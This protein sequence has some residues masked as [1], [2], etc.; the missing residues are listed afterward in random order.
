MNRIKLVKSQKVS[1]GRKRGKI[2]RAEQT[3]EDKLIEG[4]IRFLGT[5]KTE[6]ET[7]AETVRIAREHG[8]EAYDDAKDYLPGRR[9]YKTIRNR[10]AVFAVMGE[11]PLAAGISILLA[12][13]DS[14]RLDVKPNPVYAEEPCIYFDTHYYGSIKKYQWVTI[15]LAL[16]GRVVKKDGTEIPIRIGENA[17]D[18]VLN[19]S[20]LPPHI[21]AR[22]LQ[23][24]AI[25]FIDGERLNVI[26]GTGGD[27]G[28]ADAFYKLLQEK[29][30]IEKEDFISADI[31]IVPAV[32]PSYVGLDRSMI[33]GY[34]QDD[35]VCVFTALCSLLAQTRPKYTSL[36]ILTDR[37]EVGSSGATGI[38]SP[39][40]RDFIEDLAD[41]EHTKIRKVMEKSLCFSADVI[42]TAD[43]NFPEELEKHNMCRLGGG[44][45]ISRYRGNNGKVD[46]Q[47]ATAE[48]LALTRR[49]F[50][51]KHVAFQTG[52]AGKVDAGGGRTAGKFLSN[53]NVDTV[54]VGVPILSMHSPYEITAVSDVQT[55]Y[56]AYRAFLE[57]TESI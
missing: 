29:Y 52:E 10:S 46:T 40:F 30:N 51:E 41:R 27:N 44:A 13:A 37:E 14:P 43:P 17:G 22:Q 28:K 33:G 11:Q 4:Y 36:L 23:Q 32:K 5:A 24:K 47:D 25:D 16:H 31:A 7:I 8:F 49:L 2:M 54:D 39:Y 53:Y 57:R 6:Q 12:H 3:E 50:D 15:P 1:T 21:S 9:I 34:G 48:L 20:D 42:T 18:P 26:A 55:A 45:V 56:R 19:I 38:Q 35:R